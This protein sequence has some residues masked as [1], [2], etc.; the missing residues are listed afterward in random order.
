[1]NKGFTLLEIIVVLII[2]GIIATLAFTQYQG[3]IEKSRISEAK[4]TLGAL[5]TMITAYYEEHDGNYPSADEMV[6]Q[7]ALPGSCTDTHYFS[8]SHDASG[9][10]TATRCTSGGKG[11][12]GPSDYT[13]TLG[14]DGTPGGRW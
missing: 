2:L 11:P 14:P 1:M 10:G 13:V 5:R 6:T 7:L 12:Q 9:T 4:T 3:I 8:Y